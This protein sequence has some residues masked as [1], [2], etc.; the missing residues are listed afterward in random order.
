MIDL[1]WKQFVG[2]FRDALLLAL[3][4]DIIIASATDCVSLGFSY[5]SASL[6]TK[7]VDGLSRLTSWS[8]DKS[9]SSLFS[10]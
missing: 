7:R 10:V 6:R 5:M 4:S 9:P 3:Y 1:M 2:H 8:S